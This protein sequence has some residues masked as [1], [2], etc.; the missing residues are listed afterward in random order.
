MRGSFYKALIFAV[1]D[2]CILSI[3]KK[4]HSYCLAIQIAHHVTNFA[5][6]LKHGPLESLQSSGVN[7]NVRIV[8]NICTNMLLREGLVLAAGDPGYQRLSV[9]IIE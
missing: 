8:A 4:L 3:S 2:C 7:V 6:R 5:I 9:A 1:I